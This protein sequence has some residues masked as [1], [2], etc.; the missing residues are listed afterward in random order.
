[1]RDSVVKG[2]VLL[3]SD[4]LDMT[5]YSVLRSAVKSC[6]SYSCEYVI[7]VRFDVLLF[8]RKFDWAGPIST[9]VAFQVIDYKITR[10]SIGSLLVTSKETTID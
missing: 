7:V 4:L 2:P 3:A 6:G 9:V 10:D 8:M 5:S 1:M